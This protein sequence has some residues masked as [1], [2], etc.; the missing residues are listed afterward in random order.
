MLSCG[1][2]Q[3]KLKHDYSLLENLEM[4]INFL[5]VFVHEKLTYI[6]YNLYNLCNEHLCIYQHNRLLLET[7]QL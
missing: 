5:D 3:N 6:I 2:I 7:K 1:H 4:L